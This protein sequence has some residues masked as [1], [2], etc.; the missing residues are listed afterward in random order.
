ML[1]RGTHT[2]TCFSQKTVT[3]S[4]TDY[5]ND[6]CI[7]LYIISARFLNGLQFIT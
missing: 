5:E 4:S 6:A 7:R 3:K 1:E 2:F